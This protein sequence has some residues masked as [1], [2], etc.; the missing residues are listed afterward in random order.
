MNSRSRQRGMTV[1]E[2]TVSLVVLGVA[3][4][5]VVQLVALAAS[6]R[7]AMAQRRIALQEIANQAERI[8]LLPWSE[9]A[10]DKLTGW[11]PSAELSEV[12]PAAQCSIAVS[13]EPAA[14][15]RKIRLEV[16]WTNSVGQPME[17]VGLSIWR[18][19]EAAP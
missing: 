14:P 5:A 11:Q 9:T 15:A 10:P 1:V 8:A 17:P 2:L 16:A 6:Q 7:R 18:F 4:A 13:E 3:M 19:G 12:L